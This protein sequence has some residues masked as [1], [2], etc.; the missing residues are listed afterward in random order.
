MTNLTKKR[1]IW[2][3]GYREIES[4]V[5]EKARQGSRSKKLTYHVFT[6]TQEVG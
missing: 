4:I 2:A 6:Y 1:L 3:Y 5:V